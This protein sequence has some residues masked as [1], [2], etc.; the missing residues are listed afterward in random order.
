[1]DG[2]LDELRPLAGR[3]LHTLS[4]HR[5]FDVLSVDMYEVEIYVHSKAKKRRVPLTEIEPAWRTLRKRGELSRAEIEEHW[6]PRNPAYVAAM[7]AALPGI[8][9]RSKPI[10]RLYCREKR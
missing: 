4:Q 7:L 10:I 6:S 1:M 5:R 8:T 9:Y 2:L 3:T